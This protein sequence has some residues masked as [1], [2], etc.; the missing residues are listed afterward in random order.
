[1][2]RQILFCCYVVS[3]LGANLYDFFVDA[4]ENVT[5]IKS[6]VD[7]QCP[8]LG[9]SVLEGPKLEKLNNCIT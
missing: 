4:R 5:C 7:H 1:M 6:H 8:I 2:S 3:Q 9:S